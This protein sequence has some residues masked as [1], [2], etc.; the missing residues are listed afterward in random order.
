M[1]KKYKGDWYLPKSEKSLPGEL[2]FDDKLRKITLILFSKIYFTG[3][4]IIKNQLDSKRNQYNFELILGESSHLFTLNNC[5][6]SS[7]ESIGKLT[8]LVYNIE[9]AFSYVHLKGIKGLKIKNIEVKFPFLSSFF[10]GFDSLKDCIDKTEKTEYS[11]PLCITEKLNLK[12]VDNYDKKITS[13][14]DG[15]ELKYS[16]TI[17]FEYLNEEN[18]SNAFKDIYTFSKLLS[19]TTKKAICF[20]IKSITIPI[21]FINRYDKY[22]NIIE[23]S[24]P[25]YVTNFTQNESCDIKETFLHQNFMLF[26]KFSFNDEESLIHII[27]MWFQNKKLNPI[28]DFYIDSNNWFKGKNVILSNVMFNNK[29]LN[30]IQGIESY[31]DI[32]DVEFIK[33]NENFTKKRQEV[34][35]LIDSPELSKWINTNLKF[36][37]TPT[38]THKLEYFIEKFQDV[39]KGIKNIGPFIEEYPIKAKD[40]RHKLSH[41]RIETTYQGENFDK[42]YSFSKVLLCFCILDS[43]KINVLGIRSICKSN[44][45]LNREFGVITNP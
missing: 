36:P 32:L 43:L 25:C 7:T 12:L 15:Y 16:K 45:N 14:N 22:F 39:F 1:K 3:E 34:L 6:L 38:L 20:E 28:Y 2:I 44:E 35:N 4:T 8:K 5:L 11:E 17:Q 18:F 21:K 27:K 19:F 9:Y 26:S 13:F 37:K 41:G 42:I 31:Y 30:L 24:F 40:Y 33:K 10:D 29:F 23:N